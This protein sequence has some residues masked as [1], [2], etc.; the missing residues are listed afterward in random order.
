MAYV[1]LRWLSPSQS[2]CEDIQGSIMIPMKR[3]TAVRTVMLA[4]REV[5]A[6]FLAATA[7]LLACSSGI[8]FHELHTSLFSFVAQYAQKAGP[9][10]IADCSAE[11]TAPEHPLDVQAFRRNQTVSKDQTASNLIVMLAPQTLDA[12]VNL[13]KTANSLAA[14]RSALPLAGNGTASNSQLGQGGFEIARVGF[15]LTVAGGQKRFQAD[16]DTDG[17][18][19]RRLNPRLAEVARRDDVPLACL[20]LQGKRFNFSFNGPMQLYTDYADV[21]NSQT[22]I[23]QPASVTI[24]WEC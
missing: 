22:I 12:S 10:G 21:L 2:S 24:H 17:R 11:S 5:F 9:T 4:N 1:N 23:G 6:H 3:Q 20:S 13:L 15:V 18:C 14:I 16:V 7:A 19:N 8:N